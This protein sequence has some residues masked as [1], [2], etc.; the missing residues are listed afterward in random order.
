MNN[1]IIH[2]LLL[3]LLYSDYT[4]NHSRIPFGYL[5]QVQVV[6][7]LSMFSIVF[8][9][10]EVDRVGNRGSRVTT[11][12]DVQTHLE[13]FLNMSMRSTHFYDKAFI[14]CKAEL[15]VLGLLSSSARLS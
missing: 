13:A 3:M 11:M 15:V 2:N 5:L 9:A 14:Y 8:I 1:V 6:R 10:A 4:N 12:V 7:I